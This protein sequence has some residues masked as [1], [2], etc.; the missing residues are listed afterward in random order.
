MN[1]SSSNGTGSHS[2]MGNGFGQ[3][4]GTNIDAKTYEKLRAIQ[5]IKDEAL[6]A[7]KRETELK[8]NH[9]VVQVNDVVS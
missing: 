9:T 3:A 8:A 1:G 6:Q 7:K 2:N 5:R 4:L